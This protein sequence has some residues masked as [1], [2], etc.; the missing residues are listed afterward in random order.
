M[1]DRPPAALSVNTCLGTQVLQAN[2]ARGETSL[3]V[4]MPMIDATELKNA[5]RALHIGKAT[6]ADPADQARILQLMGGDSAADYLNGQIREA[7]VGCALH[8]AEHT[9]ATDGAWAAVLNKASELALANSKFVEAEI[10]GRHALDTRR[11][12]LGPSHPLTMRSIINLAMVLTERGKLGENGRHAE[13]EGLYRQILETKTAVLTAEHPE[14]IS[15]QQKL[16]TCIDAQGRRR[17]AEPMY[18]EVLAQRTKLLGAE[19]PDTLAAIGNLAACIKAL[20]AEEDGAQK[21]AM[22][23]ALYRQA[24]EAY[25]R[26]LGE[27]HPDTI[28][29]YNNLAICLD[30]QGRRSEAEPMFFKVLEQRTRLLG[31]DHATTADAMYNL[32]GLLEAEGEYDEALRMYESAKE[33]YNKNYGPDHPETEDAG[34]RALAMQE[35]IGYERSH[36]AARQ[37][38]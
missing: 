19:H 35:L 18:R 30:D 21:V 27:E 26:V 6:T 36:A 7:I 2:A 20:G 23:E 29:A 22:A 15:W 11:Q 9:T 25:T 24:L 3:V 28:H 38:Q 13:A 31:P 32:G 4:L 33:V 34:S 17:D 14:T 10:M 12:V 16:A 8:E 5:F 37:S 1:S